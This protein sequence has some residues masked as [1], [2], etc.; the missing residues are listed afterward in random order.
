MGFGK[1]PS[2]LQEDILLSLQKVLLFYLSFSH[3]IDRGIDD[4]LVFVEGDDGVGQVLVDSV[5]EGRRHIDGDIRNIM[6][7]AMMLPEV[8]GKRSDGLSSFAFCDKD[9]TLF[10]QIHKEGDIVMSFCF[11][12]FINPYRGDE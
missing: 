4:L 2:V 5:D 6:R 7:I 1:V 10:R 8:L 12:C 9:G 3:L 11:C